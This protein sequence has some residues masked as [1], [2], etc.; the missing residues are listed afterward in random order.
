[1]AGLGGGLAGGVVNSPRAA[2]LMAVCLLQESEQPPQQAQQQQQ[3][4][5]QQGLRQFRPAG[6]AA[7]GV[8]ERRPGAAAMCIALWLWGH[9]ATPN[10]QLL[11]L[12][13]RDETLERPTAPTHFWE[14]QPGVLAGRDLVA[15]GT[16]LAVGSRGRAAWLTNF[17]QMRDAGPPGEAPSRGALPLH[18]VTAEEPQRFLESI[19]TQAYPGFN[20][21][22]ADLQS[23][24]LLYLCNRHGDEQGGGISTEGSSSGDGG[25]DGSCSSS[26][27][28]GGVR[29][30]ELPPGLHGVTNGHMDSH[31]PKVEEGCRRIQQLLESGAFSAAPGAADG[32]AS[33]AHGSGGGA[34]AARTSGG[35]GGGGGKGS[36]V[37]PWSQLFELLCDEHLL[38]QRPEALP[39]TGYGD[40]FEAH[41]SGIFVRPIETQWG[42]FGTRSQIVLAVWKDGRAELRER[43]RDSSQGGAWRQAQHSLQLA[44]VGCG[45]S[46]GAAAPP[47]QYTNER[48]TA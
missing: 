3:Q 10:L 40:A 8:S 39:Q 35:G 6:A 20:L 14:D 25:G 2:A 32:H 43:Y 31:W 19:D 5:Q 41:V 12:F 44:A 42:A 13:N 11:L 37:V 38:E 27:S 1:M 48:C 7:S 21:T 34:E 26:R 29:P 47:P 33:A 30:R 17:R 22:G 24:R 4:Q 16:W 46:C 45:D 23:G 18:F 15:G 9:E 36:T 28:S